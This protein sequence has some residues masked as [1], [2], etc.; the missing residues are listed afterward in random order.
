MQIGLT[1]LSALDVE[2]TTK[3]KTIM[4]EVSVI[5]NQLYHKVIDDLII[6]NLL[7]D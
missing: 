6:I 2:E 7:S 3:A 1:E 5:Y 4:I